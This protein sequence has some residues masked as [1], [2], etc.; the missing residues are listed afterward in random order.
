MAE[1]ALAL[2]ETRA[3]SRAAASETLAARKRQMLRFLR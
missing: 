1:M 2:L 3:R